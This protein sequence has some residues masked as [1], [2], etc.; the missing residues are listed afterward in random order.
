MEAPVVCAQT[1]G[2]SVYSQGQIHVQ[3]LRVAITQQ[4]LLSTSLQISDSSV[5]TDR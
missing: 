3:Y 5:L 4:H 1:N 2:T